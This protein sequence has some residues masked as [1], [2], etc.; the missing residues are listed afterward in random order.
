MTVGCLGNIPFEVSSRA[1]TLL[2]NLEH[3]GSATY[4]THQRHLSGALVEFSGLEPESITFDLVLSEYLGC[5]VESSLNRLWSY[6][7]SATAVSFVL[8]NRTYGK[9]RWVITDLKSK[10]DYFGRRGEVTQA[11]VSVTLQEYLKT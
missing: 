9:Y 5:K 3:S 11:T 1:V 2:S 8:G 4:Q 6:M 10:A 7:Q